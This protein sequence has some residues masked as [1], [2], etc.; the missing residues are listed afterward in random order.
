MPQPPLPRQIFRAYD[1]RG[2]APA[3]IDPSVAQRIGAAFGGWLSQQGA[4]AAA[5]GHDTRATSPALYEA[6]IDGLRRA[7]LH[8]HAAGLA[9]TP[10]VGWTIDRLKADG[11]LMVTASHNP[12]EFNG[13]KLLGAE[14]APLLP[15]EI[16]AVAYLA[17]ASAPSP[18]SAPGKRTEIDAV[19]PYLDL[20]AR[21]FNQAAGLRIGVDPGNGA[22]C[23][24]GP[25]ALQ[26]A[27]ATVHALHSIP[28][29]GAPN[30]NADP[31]DPDTMRSLARAVRTLG[32]D[33]GIAWD[34]DGD[35][36]GI[37][38]HRGRRYEAD[39][40]TALL[41]R[42]LLDRQPRSPILLDRKTSTSAAEYITAHGG[43]PL[44]E[45]TGYSFVRRRMRAER[46]AFAGETSGHI[47]FGPDYRPNEHYP[48]LDD[49]VYAACAL[50]D[51]LARSERSLAGH[52][53]EFR[54]RPISPELRL[55]CPDDRKTA[56]A[57]AIG[58][59]FETHQHTQVERADGARISFPGGWAHARPS[60]TAPVLSL[61]FETDDETT[62]QQI[63]EQLH[64]ALSQH[65]EVRELEHL[66]APPTIGP[67]R[68][69]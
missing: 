17:E 20:L 65:K 15:D 22:T 30:H 21:R 45:R 59:H 11:G 5:I 54:S 18:P 10:V 50:T 28:R 52:F 4:T 26:T 46:I 39:W 61:R 56:I 33:C 36:I 63:A 32:L 6:A 37:L 1:I 64:E 43:R 49:G 60:N 69:D 41:A 47:M 42:P 31:Q 16:A 34:G 25:A 29:P 19:T 27:G 67:Q 62:Y 8:V 66:T 57:Q 68:I 48:W 38:D 35:R 44:F 14:A 9:P 3:E 51:L 12:P 7:G 55:P 23:L 58:D 40:L 53:S 2:L 13:F 24:T